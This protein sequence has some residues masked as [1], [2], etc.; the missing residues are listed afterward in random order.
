MD[1]TVLIGRATVLCAIG[2]GVYLACARFFG[3]DELAKLERILLRKLKFRR[4]R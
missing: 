2:L 3:I 1:L 4:S